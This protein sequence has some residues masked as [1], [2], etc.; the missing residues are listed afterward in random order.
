MATPLP[1]L[2]L[3]EKVLLWL[4]HC[5]TRAGP[6]TG[7]PH[8][9]VGISN[10][11]GLSRGHVSRTVAPLLQAA[12]LVEREQRVPGFSRALV[13]Y[14][15][16]AEGRAQVARL[17]EVLAPMPIETRRFGTNPSPMRFDEA[18]RRAI[19]DLTSWEAVAQL[20]A[21]G[22]VDLEGPAAGAA[23]APRFHRELADAPPVSF[24]VGRDPEIQA[25]R[26]WLIN[27]RSPYY[28]LEAA[29]GF[30]KTTL[31]AHA[32]RTGPPKMHVL[33]FRATEWSTGRTLLERVDRLLHGLGRGSPL[34]PRDE[35][36]ALYEH[37]RPRV[38]GFPLL[39]I[40]D[41][42]QKAEPTLRNVFEV[43][44]RVVRAEPG[45][46]LALLGR[47]VDLPEELLRGAT[48]ARLRPLDDRESERLLEGL[49]VGSDARGGL[50]AACRGVPLFLEIM[51]RNP[52]RASRDLDLARFLSRDLLSALPPAQREILRWAS[53]LRAPAAPDLFE[54]LGL[55]SPAAI[56]ELAQASLLARR[57]DGRYAMHDLV[58]EALYGQLEFSERKRIHQG[59][60]EFFQPRGEAW[61]H[62]EE[63]LHH[64]VRAG[65]R[66]QA[67]R[68]VLRN[69]TGLLARAHEL[70]T[71]S[72]LATA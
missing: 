42:V 54:R 4:A 57:E 66:E 37:L 9:Q 55:G 45:F 33:W 38:R 46:K 41:D 69:Q 50:A 39:V 35:P 53:A 58:R 22:Y 26:A 70:F 59:L 19:P 10:A 52:D 14:G 11:T 62:V 2:S 16:T 48:R 60:A 18:L 32:L 28:V 61:M 51:A 30:G 7:L 6:E 31:A 15:L 34:P 5:E 3:K 17:G 44:A 13:A 27:E 8:T 68:W 49:G 65:Q 12:W 36:E 47:R 56:R 64:L 71:R 21:Q 29:A 40:V 25:F 43:L 63:F 20:E 24:F 23:T 67:A 1:A 72:R